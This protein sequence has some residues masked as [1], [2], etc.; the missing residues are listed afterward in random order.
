MLCMGLSYRLFLEMTCH[1]HCVWV[2]QAALRVSE[3]YNFDNSGSGNQTF[4]L[5]Q[6]LL[7]L[8]MNAY[9]FI[10]LVETLST[11]YSTSE[12]TVHHLCDCVVQL[13]AQPFNVL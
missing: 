4:V 10:T 7:G 5:L 11:V 2:C 13:K 9:S 3:F 12:E 1:Q 6:I 8:E